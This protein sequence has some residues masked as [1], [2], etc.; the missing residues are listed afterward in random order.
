MADKQTDAI[1][2]EMY[3]KSLDTIRVYN[4][5]DQDYSVVWDGFKHVIPSKNRDAGQGKGQRLLPRYIA[6]KYVRDMKNKLIYEEGEQKV[7]QLLED[8]PKELKIKY[9][10]DPYE[11]QKLYDMAPRVDNPTEIAK[12][13][14]V[15]WLG[16]E[17]QYGLDSP[18]STSQPEM[19]DQRPIEEQIL[20]QMETKNP[21]ELD[22][23]PVI[24]DQPTQPLIQEIPE[25]KY[26][27]N[28]KKENVIKEVAV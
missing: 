13:Y 24:K 27:I 22:I 23:E 26:P 4:P 9:E 16:V 12:W 11:R 14:K 21:D 8:A 20:E 7:K 3:R 2:R 5:T 28:K 25:A 6:E 18:E 17:E 10:A 1:H 19:Q 15:L